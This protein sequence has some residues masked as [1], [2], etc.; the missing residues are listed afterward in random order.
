MLIGSK[1]SSVM[2][3]GGLAGTLKIAGPA[4]G[5]SGVGVAGAGVVVGVVASGVLALSSVVAAGF[6]SA[7]FSLPAD[8]SAGIL[9]FTSAGFCSAA[10]FASSSSPLTK[11]ENKGNPWMPLVKTPGPV[12]AMAGK[13]WCKP[14]DFL[15]S[16]LSLSVLSA[17]FLGSAL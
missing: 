5:D 10:F 8:F 17:G 9:D 11:A 3:G 12:N 14:L 15:L 2:M 1:F 4:G 13:P 7:G 6:V 16:E